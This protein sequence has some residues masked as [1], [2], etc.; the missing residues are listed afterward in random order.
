MSDIKKNNSKHYKPPQSKLA[1]AAYVCDKG[2]TYRLCR[3]FHRI[4]HC[5]SGSFQGGF[6]ALF[7]ALFEFFLARARFILGDLESYEFCYYLST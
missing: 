2:A 3:D 4:S 6:F 1:L 5:H 7:C